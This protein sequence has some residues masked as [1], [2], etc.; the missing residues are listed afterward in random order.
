MMMMVVAADRG[1]RP[2]PWKNQTPPI[3]RSTTPRMVTPDRKT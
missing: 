1:E 2:I 3:S